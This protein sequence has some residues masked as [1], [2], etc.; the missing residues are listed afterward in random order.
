MTGAAG[1]VA[2]VAPDRLSDVGLTKVADSMP[3]GSALPR[4]VPDEDLLFRCFTGRE[5][6][7]TAGR[8]RPADADEDVRTPWRSA[9]IETA[10]ALLD[11]RRRIGRW[12]DGT[13][14]RDSAHLS[15]F[16]GISGVGLALMRC[17]SERNI[18]LRGNNFVPRLDVDF[19]VAK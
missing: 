11:T 13:R 14:A 7:D 15:I 12:I 8:G 3:P 18:V 9:A 2:L 1:L 4:G 6:L 10:E 16:D 17:C 5:G 19:D